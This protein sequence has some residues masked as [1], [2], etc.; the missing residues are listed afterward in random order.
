MESGR[1]FC[2]V[3]PLLQRIHGNPLQADGGLEVGAARRVDGL[4]GIVA[5][6]PDMCKLPERACVSTQWRSSGT[7]CLARFAA[8]SNSRQWTPERYGSLDAVS[9]LLRLN[10]AMLGCLLY[11]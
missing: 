5:S 9:V 2:S 6:R 3:D 11:F 10:R 4:L 1:P 7:L 8:S